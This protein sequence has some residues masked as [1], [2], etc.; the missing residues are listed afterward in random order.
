MATE[1]STG[2]TNRTVRDWLQIKQEPEKV[3]RARYEMSKRALSERHARWRKIRNAYHGYVADTAKQKGRANFH[4]HKIFPLIEMEAARFMLN[5]FRHDPFVTVT[6]TNSETVESAQRHEEVIQ[7][8]LEHCPSWYLEKLRLV[9]YT[10]LYGCGFEMPSWRTTKRKVRKNV[11]ITMAGTVVGTDQVE[12]EDVVYDGLWFKTISPTDVFPYPYAAN[13]STVPWVVVVE[14]VHIQDILDRAQQGI[15]DEAQVNKIPLNGHLQEEWEFRRHYSD[16]GHS[17]PDSDEELICLQH[18]FTRDRF[19]TLANDK[20]VIRDEPNIFWHGEIPM[21]QGVKTLDPD[22]FWPI[23]S[24]WPKMPNQKMLSLFMNT[25]IDNVLSSQWQS[26]K[27]KAGRVNPNYLLS[28]PNH[29]IPVKEMD[30]VE[31]IQPPE[32][33][34]DIALLKTMVEAGDDELMGYFG[35]QKGY[36]QQRQTAT[37]DAI[38]QSEGNQRIQYDVMTLENLTLIPEARMISKLVQQFMP[39]EMDVRIN[40]PGG[41]QFHRLSADQVRGEFDFKA[42]GSSE[43][44]NRAVVQQQLIEL[45]ETSKDAV[46]HV[47]MGD[48]TIVPVPV[49][50]AYQ[51]L[52]EL[53]EGYGRRNTDKLLYRPEVFGLPLNNELLNSYGLPSIPGLDQLQ[54]NPQTGALR[55]QQSGGTPL[56]NMGRSTNVTDITR[57]A[58]AQPMIASA[59]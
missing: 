58:N 52:K 48:G 45:Y 14:F 10:G 55:N 51:A 21:V 18:M 6:P 32:M 3:I 50:D 43:A 11:N 49:L 7:H 25:M 31:V 4:Y 57:R 59:I 13:I 5:Y 20:V 26:W 56:Q 1:V 29:R 16:L 35:A 28:M 24:G 2:P 22:S 53:Y 30:D 46:Q 38:F 33:K 36:S 19:Q 15:F 8:Y 23:G 44:L 54:R 9:K 12:V 41:Y 47:Q 40:G 27:Y 39:E 37:S 42:Q 34:Q 17:T